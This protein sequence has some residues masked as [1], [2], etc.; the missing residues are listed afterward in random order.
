M[1]DTLSHKDVYPF[2]YT[3]AMGGEITPEKV[4]DNL[5]KAIHA[6]REDPELYEDIMRDFG[7]LLSNED[8]VVI[9]GDILSMCIDK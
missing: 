6:S 4:Y 9:N 5:V 3:L 1:R 2:D 7:Y 8:I